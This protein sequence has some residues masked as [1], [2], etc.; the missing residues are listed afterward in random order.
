[1]LAV[2]GFHSRPNLHSL[3]VK[4]HQVASDVENIKSSFS[5]RLPVQNFEVE[6]VSV[7]HRVGVDF[8]EEVIV[9]LVHEVNGV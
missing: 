9:L 8:A 3:R 1:M 5:L 4:W 7:S 2:R 6:P